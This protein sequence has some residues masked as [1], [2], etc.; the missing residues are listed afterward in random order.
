MKAQR[1]GFRMLR[2]EQLLQELV[3]DTYKTRKKL[4]EPA[5][6]G[7][8][9]A[10]WHRGRWS[11]GAPQAGARLVRCPACHRI[12]DR[13]PAGYVALKGPFLDAHRDQIVA[14]VRH[15]EASEK[16]EHPLQRIMNIEPAAGG[17]LVTTTDAHLARGIGEALRKA[18]RGRME[19]HYNKSDNLLRVSWTR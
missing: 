3:H 15:C 5:R 18:Y 8:C 10:L 12:R 17:L 6:C 2:R 16:L 4:P 13:F 1:G 9:G 11:W 14:R 7:D 19:F